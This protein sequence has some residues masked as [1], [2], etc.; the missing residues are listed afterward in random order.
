MFHISDLTKSSEQYCEVD[1][2]IAIW[3][4]RKLS[5]RAFSA[6]HYYPEM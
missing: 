5:H 2:T 1:V 4:K 6:A 3:E